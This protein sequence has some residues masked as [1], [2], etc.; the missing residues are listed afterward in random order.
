MTIKVKA[1]RFRIRRADPAKVPPADMGDTLLPMDDGFGPEPFPTARAAAPA[2]AAT[3]PAAETALDAIRREGLTGR[4]LRLAR[5]VAMKNGLPATSDF[6]AVR[7][8]RAAGIDPFQRNSMLELVASEGQAAASTS[9]ELQKV[10]GDGNRLPQTSKPLNVPS[11]EQRAERSLAADVMKIQ[12]DMAKRRQRKLAA[13]AVRLFFFVFLPTVLAGIYYYL[14]ATPMYSTRSEFVIQQAEPKGAGL[15]GL[16][17]GTQFATS[18]DSIAVQGY[19][20]SREAMKRL[21]ADIGFRNHFNQPQIDSLQRLA[22]DATAEAAYKLYR[23]NVKIAYDPTEGLIRMDVIAA[24]PETAAAF[25]RA[26]IG[27]AEEQVDHLTQRLREDQMQGSRES[28]AEAEA[29][30]L[31]AERKVVE[32]QEKYKVLSSEAEASLI[33]QQIAA[34]ETRLTQDKLSLAEMENNAEPNQARMVP[35]KR[36]MVALQDEIKALRSQLTEGSE[37]GLSLAQV[38]SELLVAKANVETRQMLLAQSLQSLETSRIE[39]NRQVRYLS[40][41]VSPVAPDEATFP[42]AFENTMVAMMIFAGI[43]LMISMTAAILREQVSA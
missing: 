31:A 38:Q 42:R 2:A 25:S 35:L 27:Y 28:Y 22:P 18:Q 26:L 1:S 29:S 4:Q 9:R 43:Y 7:L 40:L 15:G 11:T 36:R 32:L 8:L 30:M 41:S 21:D 20:Q 34:L 23:R 10:P 24:D 19:L 3:D 37:D 13:M 17:S 39:A 16:F 33:T 5:R 6:D 12:R 14:I